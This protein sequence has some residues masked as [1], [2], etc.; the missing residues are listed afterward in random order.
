MEIINNFGEKKII[1]PDYEYD[2]DRE[3]ENGNHDLVDKIVENHEYDSKG[4]TVSKLWEENTGTSWGEA[5]KKG[6]TDGSYENNIKLRKELLQGKHNI[7]KQE[8][9]YNIDEV[10]P[11]KDI[12]KNK[13]IKEATNFNEAFKIARNKLGANEVFEWQGKIY[14]TALQGEKFEPSEDVKSRYNLSEKLIDSQNKQVQSPYTSKEQVKLQPR[15]KNWESIKKRN[16]ELNKMDNADKINEYYKNKKDDSQYLIVDK[17]SSRMHLYKNG[18]LVD[19]F[20]VI[21]GKNKGDAQTVTKVENGKTNWEKGNNSTGAGIYTI[22]RIDPKSKSY[23][24]LPSFNLKNELGIEVSTTI[25]GTP[26]SRRKYFNDNN[27]ENNRQS[28]GCIN[29]KCTDLKELYSKYGLKEGDNVYILPEDKGNEFVYQDGNIIFKASDKNRKESL[30]YIDSEGNKQKGQGINYS[31]KTLKYKP[32]KVFINKSEFEKNVYQWNDFNDDKEYEEVTK[33]FLNALV[34]NKKEIMKKAKIPSDVY[35]E[36]VKVSFG[37]YGTESNFGDTHS[38]V[39][40]AVRGVIKGYGDSK[41]A[42]SP[43]VKKKYEG[44]NI[45]FTDKG[46]G[47]TK[48]NN[49]VG[50]TQY[51]WKWAEEDSKK[52]GK[53]LEILKSLGITSNKDFL[54][55]EK[56]AIGTI[57]VL[58][59]RYNTQLTPKE[60]EDIM[61]NL[62]KKWNNRP[63][64]TNRVKNNSR[65]LSIKQ[66]NN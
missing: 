40:N 21:T 36:L 9:N 52:G 20:E 44:F 8:D 14:N 50:Y 2:V 18:E 33:P 11:K 53:E 49:S 55:P 45:P 15:Y 5:K 3:I 56:A 47:A 25:H 1:H 28:Y 62:P 41:N 48:N 35:N 16:T 43:D 46:A 12:R 17:N 39:G 63:N 7:R 38:W 32:I 22:S 19:S 24:G 42:S 58:A 31:N 51:R 30:E 64:Y 54:D 59:Y 4:K 6:L 23:Y 60:K 13:N 57:A 10:T 26:Y 29:G 66:L 37:I 65:Y 61:S 27:V 34:T